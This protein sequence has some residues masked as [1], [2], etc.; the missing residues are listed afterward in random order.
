MNTWGLEKLQAGPGQGSCYL[1]FIYWLVSC[2]CLGAPATDHVPMVAGA[3]LS[4]HFELTAKQVGEYKSALDGDRATDEK[5]RAGD[6]GQ[7]DTCSMEWVPDKTGAPLGCV[8][9]NHQRETVPAPKNLQ[10]KQTR[11]TLGLGRQPLSYPVRMLEILKNVPL[12]N[13]GKKVK[14]LTFF[15]NQKKSEKSPFCSGHWQCVDSIGV[16]IQTRRRCRSSGSETFC[17]ERSE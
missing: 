13:W 1:L 10:A 7:S 2:W 9:Y 8:L 5:V 11:Q 15:T 14:I 12:P 17:S 4:V 16:N 6:W 3:A